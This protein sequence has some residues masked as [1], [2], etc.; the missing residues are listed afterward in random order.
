MELERADGRLRD[1]FK[2]DAVFD[3]RGCV[4]AP[5]KWAVL[6]DQRRGH[7]SWLDVGEP[8][9]DGLACIDFV[10]AADLVGRQRARFAK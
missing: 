4:F 2:D 6:G 10:F 3:G 9:D 8:F 5:D 7:T 1:L